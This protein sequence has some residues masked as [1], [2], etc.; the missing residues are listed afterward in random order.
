M[1]HQ[2]RRF[3]QSRA[4]DGDRPET[5][6]AAGQ[7]D[8]EIDTAE[9]GS[10]RRTQALCLVC[11]NGLRASSS[12]GWATSLQREVVVQKSP[13]VGKAL[14]AVITALMGTARSTPGAG[15]ETINVLG[16]AKSSKKRLTKAC[17][18]GEA[19]VVEVRRRTL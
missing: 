1:P 19:E 16:I 14:R 11:E 2:L 9:A 7:G 13:A 10:L 12:K 15:A 3:G 4:S 5:G 6:R 8:R 17:P 18:L